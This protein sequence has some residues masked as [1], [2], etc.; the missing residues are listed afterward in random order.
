MKLVSL[1]EGRYDFSSSMLDLVVN[2][3]EAIAKVIKGHRPDYVI[4]RIQD[5]MTD[6][7]EHYAVF[8]VNV[9]LRL[10]NPMGDTIYDPIGVLWLGAFE[11]PNIHSLDPNWKN[12]RDIDL[13]DP[14]A[15]DI[16][17]RRFDLNANKKRNVG[18]VR[19]GL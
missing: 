1:H 7:G 10:K 19:R 14:D 2:T 4:G 18:S 9:P 3:M 11:Y 6:A 17:L 5:G 12:K 8:T 15:M 13:N 16:I